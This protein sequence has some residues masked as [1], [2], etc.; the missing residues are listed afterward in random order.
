MTIH[1]DDKPW[2][3]FEIKKHS[4]LRDRL[5]SK[6]LKSHNPTHWQT[7]K[8][9]RNKVNN[10][11]KHAKELFYSNL[12]NNLTDTMPNNKQD[13]W[14]IVRHF[15]KENKSSGSIPPL[16]IT[17]ENNDTNMYVTDHE[18]VECLNGY[19]TSISTISDEQPE[20]PNLFPKTDSKGHRQTINFLI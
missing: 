19:F 7:Y 2:Y 17:D 16:L 20:L 14:K 18:K 6:A 4:R 8:S 10:L 5:R 9:A 11:K 1:T 15:V 12:E 13:F 3:D